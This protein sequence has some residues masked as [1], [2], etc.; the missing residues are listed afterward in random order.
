MSGPINS[1]VN[2]GRNAEDHKQAFKSVKEWLSLHYGDWEVI[3]PCEV[4]T[5]CVDPSW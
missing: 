4:G 5:T 3:N 2:S 1:V